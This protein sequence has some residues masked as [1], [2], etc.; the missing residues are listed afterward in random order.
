MLSADQVPNRGR[1]LDRALT[2][3]GSPDPRSHRVCITSLRPYQFDSLRA[4]RQRSGRWKYDRLLIPFA[5]HHDGPGHARDF[6]GKCDGDNLGRLAMQQPGEPRPLGSMALRAPD[7][8]QGPRPQQ[9]AQLAVTL[10]G[11]AAELLLASARILFRDKTDPSRKAAAAWKGAPVANLG[12][13]RGGNDRTD[14][15]DFLQPPACLRGAVP[16]KN[17]PLDRGD[18]VCY[19][20]IL[21][22]Q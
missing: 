21:T 17:A 13:K 1:A 19:R 15:R 2:Q 3:T 5:A 20:H 7:H 11:D 14:A 22:G 4:S 9:P 6:V 12:G 16:G 8:T 18:L 10:F